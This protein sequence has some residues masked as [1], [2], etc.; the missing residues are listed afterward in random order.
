LAA[1]AEKGMKYLFS[2]VGPPDLW[3]AV[4]QVLL[5]RGLQSV[6]II[7]AFRVYPGL[8]L[9]IQFIAGMMNPAWARNINTDEKEAIYLSFR[10]N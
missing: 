2:M 3:I 8:I 7:I 1:E 4:I 5:G 6:Y 9:S 10:K